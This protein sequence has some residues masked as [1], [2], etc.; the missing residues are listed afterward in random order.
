[1]RKVKFVINSNY[2][3]DYDVQMELV[4]SNL[5]SLG[6]R[7]STIEISNHEDLKKVK[8]KWSEDIT[9]VLA[10]AEKV[11]LTDMTAAGLRV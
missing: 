3:L 8:P 6:E 5:T 10:L 7:D 9:R 1:M 11:G 4:L 2:K